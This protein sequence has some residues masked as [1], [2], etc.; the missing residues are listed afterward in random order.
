M[1]RNFKREFEDDEVLQVNER[2]KV[3]IL[4]IGRGAGATF[5]ST[6]IARLLGMQKEKAV[7]FVELRELIEETAIASAERPANSEA[8]IAKQNMQGRIEKQLREAKQGP[9]VSEAWEE[10][11]D[12]ETGKFQQIQWSRDFTEALEAH[13]AME[14]QRKREA[15]ETQQ[16]LEIQRKR[17]ARELGELIER[18]YKGDPYM[19]DS[20]KA[21][22]HMRD[23]RMEAPYM[24]DSRMEAPYMRDSLK[25]DPYIRDS[26]KGSMYMR[27]S[28]IY[29]S[30]GIGKRFSNR[31][32]APF[33]TLVKKRKYIRGIKNMDA[34][35]N[36]ALMTSYESKTGSALT[37]LEE[38]RLINNIYGDVIICDMGSEIKI[39]RLDEMDKI[40]C[41]VDPMP[42]RLIGSRV[43][44]QNLKE[45]EH[46]GK[47]IIWII[48]KANGGINKK[49]FR[50]YI[51]IKKPITIP[52]IR[53]EHFYTA[54]YNCRIPF[55]QR[56]I[57]SKVRPQFEEIVKHI[58]AG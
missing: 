15:R 9:Y 40:I 6:S 38:A 28:L 51:K 16:A 23:S 58:I 26:F 5:V 30:I 47:E 22:P 27:D 14:I 49:C 21:A 1:N 52:L 20:L 53:P 54:E 2:L 35:V 55:E 7:A 19:R 50:E 37:A 39:S 12:R 13:Q 4:G 33:Y 48:N 56:E 8:R 36:W 29:D 31:E 46:K 42:S 17:D 41:V 34:G 11:E 57:K 44:Y 10:K 45:E 24:R 43:V 18:A 32:F 25:G 3:G